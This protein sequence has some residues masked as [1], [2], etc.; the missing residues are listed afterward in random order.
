[1]NHEFL[2]FFVLFF[3]YVASFLFNV[4]EGAKV[5][6]GDEPLKNLSKKY[7]RSLGG[8]EIKLNPKS[9]LRCEI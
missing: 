6:F 3:L 7:Q 8:K 2:M 9:K 4:D 5:D 1:M